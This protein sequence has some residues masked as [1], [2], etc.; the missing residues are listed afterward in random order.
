MQEVLFWVNPIPC[1]DSNL[2][3][4]GLCS[5]NAFIFS[6]PFL[7]VLVIC[8]DL[9]LRLDRQLISDWSVIMFLCSFFLRSH[10]HDRI[11]V[12]LNGTQVNRW[13]HRLGVGLFGRF[14]SNSWQRT[15][16]L[17]I[18]SVFAFLTIILKRQARDLTELLL[19]FFVPLLESL[20]SHVSC[21]VEL[22]LDVFSVLF[23][24]LFHD[25]L[26]AA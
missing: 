17:Q 22:A 21:L 7:R 12:I 25:A 9:L 23:E 4:Q 11:D 26:P 14:F 15:A 6:L 5:F 3:E 19:H 13:L 1:S 24:S 20:D 10:G 16:T 18:S 8:L 2:L